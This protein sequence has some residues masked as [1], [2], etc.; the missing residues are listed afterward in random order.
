MAA[1]SSK[2]YQASPQTYD[3]GR[4]HRDQQPTYT[5]FH[6]HHKTIGLSGPRASRSKVPCSQCQYH[7]SPCGPHDSMES[8]LVIFWLVVEPTHL[9]NMLVKMGIFPDFPGENN[10]YLSCH[11]LDVPWKPNFENNGTPKWM[12]KIMESPIK[13][14]YLGGLSIFL[15]APM[16]V[17][18]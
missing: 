8:M 1:A 2:T 3:I 15:E 6:A 7:T 11:H 9:K 16:L 4:M 12:V 17:I 10:K 13:I 18:F 14:H 5:S